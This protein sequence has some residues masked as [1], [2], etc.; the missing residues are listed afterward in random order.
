MLP[1]DI[2]ELE[3]V[4]AMDVVDWMQLLRQDVFFLLV[5]VWSCSDSLTTIKYGSVAQY[6]ARTHLEPNH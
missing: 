1:I 6:V 5:F 3:F 2:Q 4:G